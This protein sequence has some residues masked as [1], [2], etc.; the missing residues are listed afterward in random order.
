MREDTN[1]QE[2]VLT[3]I[4]TLMA[5]SVTLH[6]REGAL[7]VTDAMN[8][9]IEIFNSSGKFKTLFGHHGDGSGDFAMPK[10]VAVDSNGIIYVVD[11][12]F[13]N[14]QLFDNKGD[15]FLTVGSRGIGQ[16]EFWLPSGIFID[17]S[18]RLYVCDTYNH[19]I[20]VFDIISGNK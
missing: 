4:Q 15:F 13:D 14:I 7:Y 19:R 16:A 11:S 20:Q 6:E 8:Y 12:L 2:G 5:R 18:D 10:G 1:E 17:R 3:A 9:R